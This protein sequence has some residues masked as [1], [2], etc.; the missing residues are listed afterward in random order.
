MIG[1]DEVCRSLETRHL[2]ARRRGCQL[3]LDGP[4]MPLHLQEKVNLLSVAGA[5]VTGLVSPAICGQPRS[6]MSCN[7]EVNV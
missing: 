6:S 2:F 3:H 4:A 1:S 7:I 5:E